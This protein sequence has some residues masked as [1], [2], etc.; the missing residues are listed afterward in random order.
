MARLLDQAGP[1]ATA[2]LTRH[3]RA[4]FEQLT[5]G[6]ATAYASHD[7]VSSARDLLTYRIGAP[8][9]VIGPLRAGEVRKVAGGGRQAWYLGI[10]PG[11]VSLR[12]QKL[13]LGDDLSDY[14]EEHRDLIDH[15]RLTQ[16]AWHTAPDRPITDAVE[17][18]GLD[19]TTVDGIT[20]E[21][22]PDY[23]ADLDTPPSSRRGKVTEWSR[24][25]RRHMFK[26]IPQLDYSS[27]ADDGGVL[28]MVT[29]T[30]PGQWEQVA[31]DG[32]TW[33]RLIDTLRKRWIR[34]VGTPWRGLWKMEF[35]R[36]GAPHQH[37]LMRIPAVVGEDEQQQSFETWLSRT[38]A[39]LCKAAVYNR[40][41][42]DGL[43]YVAAGEYD[44]HLR[45][46]TA[47]D[48]SGVKFSDPRRTAVYFL[49][50]SSK[51]ADD[52]EYQHIVPGAWRRAEAVGRFWG[53]WGL[54]NALLE[55]ELTRED[56]DHARR[57]MRH[58]A[59][60]AAARVELA[61]RRFAGESPWEMTRTVARS[62]GSRGGGWHVAN[63]GVALAFDLARAIS[64][65]QA[66]R[67]DGD[68][69]SS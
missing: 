10:S 23:A 7:D 39:D 33:K 38:W 8:S 17:L 45:A 16:R 9:S 30:L 28:A 43:A 65:R 63:D 62:F 1:V 41:T 12:T 31:P 15:T 27:W 13:H 46:G 5:A 47:V 34:E 59:R 37:M 60:A 42:A 53:Y 11:T 69:S 56:F 58:V 50:H 32:R 40:S 61:R 19:G 52:K 2:P 66:Q 18:R 64:M 29:L 25:S 6:L 14:C 49:K 35:Q 24:A 21:D 22:Y 54:K 57:I 4:E 55:L 3:E 44:K 51:A 20:I 68:V 26:T 48:F 36:R 67:L